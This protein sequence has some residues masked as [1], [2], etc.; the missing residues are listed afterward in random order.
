MIQPGLERISLLLKDVEFPWKAIHVA[1]TNGKGSICHYAASILKRRTI[2]VGTFNSPHLVDRWDCIKINGEPV[3][4]TSFTTI[5]KQFLTR[6]LTEEINASPF[7]ILTATALA[8]FNKA[9]VQVG[10]VEVGMGGRLD[11]TNIINN[12]CISVISKI[13]RDHEAFL[14]STLEEIAKHKAGIL[15]P[16]V[17][18][19]VNPENEFH[20]Q[21]VI[22]EYAK[23]IGAGPRL[24]PD[25]PAL[26]KGLYMTKDW[27]AFAQPKATWQRDNAALAIVAVKRAMKG[28]GTIEDDMIANELTKIR[29]QRVTGRLES[30]KIVPVFGSAGLPGRQILVDG[31]HNIDA[32]HVLND[33]VTKTERKPKD[34]HKESSKLHG[35][36]VTW[37]LAMT[38]GR[39]AEAFLKILLRPGDK[40][41]TTSFGPV[42]GMPWVQ[43]IDPDVLL[44]IVESIHPTITALAMPPGASPLR[45]LCAA[46]YLTNSYFD[47]PIVL[48][49][50]LYLIGDLHRAMRHP[51]GKDGTFNSNLFWTQSI[52]QSE[53]AMMLEMQN[54]ERER[55]KRL[56]TL[57]DTNIPISED[58]MPTQKRENMVAAVEQLE[59]EIDLIQIEQQQ[60]A[61]RTLKAPTQSADVSWRFT[62][63]K[64]APKIPTSPRKTIEERQ[65]ALASSEVP[66]RFQKVAPG[67]NRFKLG[68]D[69]QNRMPQRKASSVW[70][71]DRPESGE[72]RESTLPPSEHMLNP[73]V[74]RPDFLRPGNQNDEVKND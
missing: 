14:G 18:Y 60:V 21:H 26:R 37:V 19:T 51:N 48:T 65:N 59:R 56:M 35:R 13:A 42:D 9:K 63:T 61:D 40:V 3:S 44:K 73:N 71:M 15:R 11:A 30:T 4:K 17:P 66:L 55:V 38:A 32:A 29:T 20:V 43:P 31:A 62:E 39:D 53:R 2:R 69:R 64:S 57:R 45:A 52:F 16:N 72:K 25:S 23:E 1:G 5:E 36:P 28:L 46:K 8:C 47:A 58:E 68:E 67:L 41:V 74:R 24:F 50:S 70:T 54:E 6:N 27:R 49:G 34:W 33:W 10:I 12:Q 7:E 22:D